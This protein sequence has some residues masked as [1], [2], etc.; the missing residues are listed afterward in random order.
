MIRANEMQISIVIPTYNSA[1]YIAEAIESIQRQTY[2]NWQII[3]SDGASSDETLYII[4]GL[5]VPN[6]K[7]DSRPDNG[8]SDALNRGFEMTDGDILC[9]L[10][11]DDVYLDPETFSQVSEAFSAGLDCA[12]GH[13]AVIDEAGILKKKLYAYIS[14]LGPERKNSNVFTGSLFFSRRAW[15]GFGGFSGKYKLSFESEIYRYLLENYDPNILNVFAAAFRRHG[16]GLS[17]VFSKE[18]A[19]ERDVIFTDTDQVPRIKRMFF[20]ALAHLYQRNLG[21][22]IWN[23]FSSSEIGKGWRDYGIRQ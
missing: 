22:V 12:I 21:R 13:M 14:A 4:E 20:R 3:V 11:S 10:N 23:Y 15:D 18:L 5:R 8:V 17:E 16:A 9:W 2:T 1:K 7:I 19:I 6:L